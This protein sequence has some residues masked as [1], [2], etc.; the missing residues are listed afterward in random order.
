MGTKVFPK[1]QLKVFLTASIQER[2]SRRYKQ[3]LE[4]GENVSLRALEEQVRLRDERDMNRKASPLAIASDAIEVDTS[5]LSIK[6]AV[7][8]LQNLAILRGIA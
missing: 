3:L 2:A 8:R 4:Q 6:E 1:A 7:D 5:D